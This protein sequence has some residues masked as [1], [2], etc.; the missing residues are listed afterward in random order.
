VGP[1]RFER[2]RLF[3][4]RCRVRAAII[5]ALPA[6]DLTNPPQGRLYLSQILSGGGYKTQFIALD[7]AG[8]GGERIPGLFTDAG[9]VLAADLFKTNQ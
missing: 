5:G 1:I 9:E 3:D 4:Y 2:G 6:G 7:S 8:S